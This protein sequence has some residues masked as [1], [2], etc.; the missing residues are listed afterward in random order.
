M[1]TPALAFTDKRTGQRFY[2]DPR[3]NEIYPSVTT[4]IGTAR[5]AKLEAWQL[6]QVAASAVDDLSALSRLLVEKGAPAAIRHL[7]AAPERIAGE[8]AMI[9]DEVHNYIEAVSR[10]MPLPAVSDAASRFIP[11]AHA[12]LGTH[13]PRFVAMEA[14]VFNTELGFAGTADFIAGFGRL[15]LIGDYKSGKTVHEEVAMQLSAL[16]HGE[17]IVTPQ[18]HAIE[19]PKLDGG[20]VVHIRPNAFEVAIT[21]ITGDPWNAFVHTLECWKARRSSAKW[22]STPIVTDIPTACAQFARSR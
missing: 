12:F 2:R 3:T 19:V 9:G 8:A 14:T 16:A 21:Q 5:V 11:A 18:G 4:I 6:K 20:I 10:S 7:A 17:H 15:T 1:T 22:V 13:K